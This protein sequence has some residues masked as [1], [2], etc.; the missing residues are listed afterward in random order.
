MVFHPGLLLRCFGA[1]YYLS[2]DAKGVILA[3]QAL[4]CMEDNA[5]K[6]KVLI[7]QTL[8]QPLVLLSGSHVAL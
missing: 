6:L 5:G 3:V 7:F 1:R 2:V 8:Y 4:R